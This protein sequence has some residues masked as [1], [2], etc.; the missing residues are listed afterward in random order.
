VNA[1]AAMNVAMGNATY[2]G[3]PD[4]PITPVCDLTSV[5]C[6]HPLRLEGIPISW[7]SRA[8]A[9]Y[10]ED[11]QWSWRV[12]FNWEPTDNILVYFGATTGYRAGGW[13]LGGT[14]NRALVDTDGLGTCVIDGDESGCDRYILQNYEA[15]EIISYE[16]GYKG[17]HLDGRLQVNMALYYYDYENYQDDVERWEDSN[18][19]FTL[20]NIVLPDGSPLGAP[21][22]RGPVSVTINIPEA[23]NKGFEIDGMYLLTDNF[24]VGGNY[25]YTIS[26]Y[27]APF[28]FF[29]E[30]DPRYPRGVFGGDLAENPCNM[31]AEIRALYCLD[32]DGM[33]LQG[34][35]K[36][37]ASLWGSYE[38]YLDSGTLNLLGSYAYTGEYSTNAFNRPWDWVPER[39][40]VDA[41]LTFREV[42]GRWQASLFV[43]NILDETYIRTADMSERLTGYGSNYPQRVVALYPRY[44]GVELTYNFGA[45]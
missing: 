44:W 19:S 25:S 29:N 41:R 45:F 38:W 16:V 28:T 33:E 11:P 5:T 9:R 7:G 14:D 13:D 10:E 3:H 39:H 17:T 27:S 30:N 18:G 42:T 24:T 34:I 2:S 31:P 23:F 40:R 35:P 36:H 6:A 22:G 15:E 1:L 12:N 32:A 20:P 4:F 8:S 37:K 26:E 43:D 21:P